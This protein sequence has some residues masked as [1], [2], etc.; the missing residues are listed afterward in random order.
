V[1]A[2]RR[3]L[4]VRALIFAG[5]AIGGLWWSQ[6]TTFRYLS[7]R[8]EEFVASFD[9]PPAASSADARRE[10]DELLDLQRMR[11]P[12]QVAAARAD[13][14]KDIARFY[15]ALGLDPAHPPALPKLHELTDTAEADIGPYVRAVKDKYRR[16]RPYEIEPRLEPCIGNVRGDLSYP[17]GHA[18]YGYLMGYLLAELVPE[19]RAALE[20]RA[21]E[22]ARQRLVC[23][24]HFPSDLEA[25]RRGA[26]W[27]LDRM[28]E[29]SAFRQD[30]IAAGEELRAALGLRPI[31]SAR[32]RRSASRPRRSSRHAAC[33]CR[34]PSSATRRTCA[35]A[36]ADPR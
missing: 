18:A 31:R 14:K 36:R 5:V 13:R 7:G 8:P 26:R 15:A 25:G 12:A 1:T 2:A 6:H 20:L 10:L 32:S 16:L 11:T 19:R 4:L 17:S 21:D 22:F 24:V 29:S 34:C 35:A 30:A 23:G 27:L 33:A 28:H 9:P 3:N